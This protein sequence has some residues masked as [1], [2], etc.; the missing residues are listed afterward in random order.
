MAEAKAGAAGAAKKATPAGRAATVAGRVAQNQSSPGQEIGLL[1]GKPRGGGSTNTRSSEG[2]RG[3]GRGAGGG[4]GGGR[5]G[6]APF[7]GPAGESKGTTRRRQAGQV[8]GAAGS[9]RAGKWLWAGNRR[10]LTAQYVACLVILFLGTLVAPSGSKDD[11]TR[12]MVKGSAL[13]GVFLILAL[14]ASGGKGPTKVAT[15][16]GTLVTAAYLL[17]SSDVHNVTAWTARFF[18]GAKNLTSGDFG[19]DDDGGDGGDGGGATG[20]GGAVGGVL[21]GAIADGT[22]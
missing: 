11:L 14:V 20:A 21:G 22:I 12:A 1:S 6:Y 10:L 13:S 16:I 9:R 5:G 18:A 3:R 7:T 15:A 17:T 19:S 4:S 2:S 8:P